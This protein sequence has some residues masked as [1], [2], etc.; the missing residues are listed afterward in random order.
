MSKDFKIKIS[1]YGILFHSG[2]QPGYPVGVHISCHHNT[3]EHTCR[4]AVGAK[5]CRCA[6]PKKMK[7]DIF[8]DI[9]R[10]YGS[11]YAFGNEEHP[12]GLQ[13]I[14]YKAYLAYKPGVF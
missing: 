10:C 13:R 14:T 5:S 2:Q 4:N 1:V 8:Y 7:Y 9:D 12:E 6:Y 11:S 3:P